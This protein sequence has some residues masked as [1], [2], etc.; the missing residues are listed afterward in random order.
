MYSGD[1]PGLAGSAKYGNSKSEAVSARF[2]T[3][4]QLQGDEA[5]GLDAFP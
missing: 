1:C 5:Q 4:V 2:F 3:L